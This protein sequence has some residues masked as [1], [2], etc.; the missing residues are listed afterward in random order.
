VRLENGVSAT[1]LWRP[2]CIGAMTTS[3]MTASRST[4]P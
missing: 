3:I 4:D 2:S 1:T